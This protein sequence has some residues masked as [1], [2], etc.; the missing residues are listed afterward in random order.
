MKIKMQ[1]FFLTCSKDGMTR[2]S[3]VREVDNTKELI[4]YIE[5]LEP[6]S[7]RKG[8]NL[9]PSVTQFLGWLL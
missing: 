5:R 3:S 9:F 6:N 7:F 2:K 1:V 8:D 4:S